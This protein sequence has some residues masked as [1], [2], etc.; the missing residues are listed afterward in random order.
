MLSELP[1]FAHLSRKLKKL[2]FK[3]LR[4]SRKNKARRLEEIQKN[5]DEIEQAALALCQL[6]NAAISARVLHIVIQQRQSEIA[7]VRL[8][9]SYSLDDYT[10]QLQRPRRSSM[11]FGEYL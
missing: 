4:T 7:K 9:K 8:R 1:I 2:E 3:T 5:R 6:F 11:T 10:E